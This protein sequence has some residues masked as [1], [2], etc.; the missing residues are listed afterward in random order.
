MKDGSQN[1]K[2][3]NCTEWT[4]DGSAIARFTTTPDLLKICGSPTKVSRSLLS[5]F[6]NK[7]FAITCAVSHS[8]GTLKQPT[9]P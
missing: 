9:K 5:D 6:S 4:T 8:H 7:Y 1:N 3:N 2:L